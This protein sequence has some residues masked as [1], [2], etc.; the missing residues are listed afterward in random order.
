MDGRDESLSR[1]FV[2][3]LDRSLVQILTAEDAEFFSSA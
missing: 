3:P 1:P 2:R